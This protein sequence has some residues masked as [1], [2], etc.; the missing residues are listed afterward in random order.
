MITAEENVK[1]DDQQSK[2]VKEA[3][4]VAKKATSFEIKTDEDFTLAG[5]FGK[6]VAGRIKAV[7]EFFAP[8]K[9]QAHKAWKTICDTQSDVLTPL[10]AAKNH[11]ATQIGEYSRQKEEERVAE[12][13]R[14]REIALRQEEDRVLAEAEHL[15]TIGKKEEAEAVLSEPVQAPVVVTRSTTPTVKGVSTRQS[16]HFQIVDEKLIP[17]EYLTPD[18][19]KIKKVVEAMKT[20]TNIPGIRVFSSDK[21]AFRA[22]K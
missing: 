5:E 12:E 1:V 21:A 13:N 4:E 8:M 7:E 18:E 6:N 10:T 22:G 3:L 2:I 15:Q 11:L 14:Q 9:T 16:W 17:R 19:F 20:M